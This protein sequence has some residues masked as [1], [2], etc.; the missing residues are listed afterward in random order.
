MS[1]EGRASGNV[2]R[3]ATIY[4]IV[5][6]EHVC[7]FGVRALALL[8]GAG[9]DVEDHWL[10]TR[11]QTDAFM[12]EHGVQTTPLIFVDG[13]PVGGCDDLVRWLKH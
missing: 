10:K 11:V 8:E 5:S 1:D 2:S 7:P 13:Q 9:F 3:H 12:A 4:R 6:P